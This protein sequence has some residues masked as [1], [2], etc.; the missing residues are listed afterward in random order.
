[1]IKGEQC[2]ALPFNFKSRINSDKPKHKAETP[3]TV[4]VKNC[5]KEW[6]HEDLYDNFVKYGT[7]TSAKMSI[8]AEFKTRG[9]AFVTYENYKSGQKAINEA[10]GLSLS[11]LTHTGGQ[12]CES[13]GDCKLVV[14]E[15]LHKHDRVS[16]QVPK[17]STNLYVKNFPTKDSGEF[18]EN[19]LR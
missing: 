11:K 14:S 4:F 13:D 19:D 10:N 16:L 3:F 12:E 17:C 15:Y 7:V 1:M 18:N 8:D 5:P 6:T 2:R 9:Y